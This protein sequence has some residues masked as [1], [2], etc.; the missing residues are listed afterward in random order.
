MLIFFPFLLDIC[1]WDDSAVLCV[2]LSA[3]HVGCP[4]PEGAVRGDGV[5]A[6]DQKGQVLANA[7]HVIVFFLSPRH[8]RLGR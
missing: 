8:M 2:D 7:V 6:G 4:V 3:C 5:V 1:V